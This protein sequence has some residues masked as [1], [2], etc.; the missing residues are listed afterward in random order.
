MLKKSKEE[1]TVRTS[2]TWRPEHLA[3]AKDEAK[4]CYDGSLS[5]LI[6][7]M[8]EERMKGGIARSIK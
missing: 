5:L 4:I 2:I 7:K 1:Q 6:R 8:V 3:W